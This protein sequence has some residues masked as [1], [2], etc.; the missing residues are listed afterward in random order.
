[1]NEGQLNRLA[2][3][4]LIAALLSACSPSTDTPEQQPGS[5]AERARMVSEFVALRQRARALSEEGRS[6]DSARAERASADFEKVV[7]D[8]RGWAS[9]FR[10]DS[11][12]KRVPNDGNCPWLTE[13]GGE[14]C[15]RTH[16]TEAFCDYF[17]VDI[18][19]V[20]PIDPSQPQ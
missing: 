10:Q 17:C 9:G 20:E 11:R 16:V 6:G 12:D 14:Q 7:S 3:V 13:E 5:D 1:M 18:P 8:L 19:E 2:S 15:V 4:A